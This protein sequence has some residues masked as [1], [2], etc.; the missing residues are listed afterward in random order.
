[1][2]VDSKLSIRMT[3]ARQAVHDY[4]MSIRDIHISAY[5]DSDTMEDPPERFLNLSVI[6]GIAHLRIQEMGETDAPGKVQANVEVP[7]KSLLRALQAFVDD[8]G[9]KIPTR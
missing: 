4:P 8:D 7:A 6:G 2:A 3:C 9:D 1:M 5:G